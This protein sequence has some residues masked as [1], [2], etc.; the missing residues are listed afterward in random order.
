MLLAPLE[1]VGDA[2]VKS[3]NSSSSPADCK[4][5]KPALL[6]AALANDGLT[7]VCLGPSSSPN[8]NI[9]ISGCLALAGW[10]FLADDVGRSALLGMGGPVGLVF[11]FL[12]DATSPSS[13]SSYSSNRSVRWPDFPDCSSSLLV[14]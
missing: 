14:D 10:G 13:Y 5:P 1:V 11:R 9:S 2:D 6:S 12:G 8:D 3:P 7:G 4:E